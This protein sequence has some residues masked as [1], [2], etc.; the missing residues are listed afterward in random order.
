[1]S[2]LNIAAHYPKVPRAVLI[3][4][5]PLRGLAYVIVV[6]VAG[7]VIIVAL[8]LVPDRTIA[9]TGLASEL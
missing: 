4:L 7:A 2:L 5:R 3:I 1:M 8:I 9:E 6:T